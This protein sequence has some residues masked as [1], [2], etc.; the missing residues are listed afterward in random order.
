MHFHAGSSDVRVEHKHRNVIQRGN[1]F[2]CIVVTNTR[3]HR[4]EDLLIIY[5]RWN[6]LETRP[7]LN[8]NMSLD[9]RSFRIRH[10]DDIFSR[11]FIRFIFSIFTFPFSLFSFFF[12]SL[13]FFLFC[14]FGIF[15]YSR[16]NVPCGFGCTAS[17][18]GKFTW[19]G[20][21]ADYHQFKSQNVP[22]TM[23]NSRWPRRSARTD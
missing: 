20:T 7:V 23:L 4:T 1:L 14:F 5:A 3:T 16:V 11:L 2:E 13:P 21:L 17:C 22:S 6:E 10:F 8:V 9:K 19:L 12:P 18:R 15:P